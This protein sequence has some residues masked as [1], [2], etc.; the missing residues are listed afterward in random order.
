MKAASKK[1]R[2]KYVSQSEAP[3]CH[4]VAQTATEVGKQK[5]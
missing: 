1:A 2:Q 5:W 4:V 3:H